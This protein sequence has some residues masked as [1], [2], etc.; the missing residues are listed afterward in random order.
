[1]L[2]PPDDVELVLRDAE[3][4]EDALIAIP[5]GISPKGVSAQDDLI[6]R[7]FGSF[8]LSGPD[9][10]VPLRLDVHEC[11]AWVVDACIQFGATGP[12]GSWSE[13]WKTRAH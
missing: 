1:M 3:H 4:G 7:D 2:L 11:G 5:R 9:R 10:S 13:G 8:A 6:I 12:R